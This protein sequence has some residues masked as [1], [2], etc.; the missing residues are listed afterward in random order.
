M[1]PSLESIR[2]GTYQPLARPIFIYVSSLGVSRPEVER[3]VDFYL[4][5]GGALAEEVGYVE[6]GSRGYALVTEHFRN[7][8][9]G[10]VFPEGSSQI[11][12]TIEQLLARERSQ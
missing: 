10:T 3:F 8:K 5:E 9:L 12:L 1:L 6:L 7:R 2:T 11:G 4:A